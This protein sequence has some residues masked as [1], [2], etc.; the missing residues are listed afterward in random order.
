MSRLWGNGD[1]WRTGPRKVE[2]L[3]RAIRGAR[4]CP[5]CGRQMVGS[6]T[7]CPVGHH[8]GIDSRGPAGGGGC[9]LALL[10]LFV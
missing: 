2:D 9:L 3:D 10:R 8:V 4:T 7:T 6:V 5:R 1:L